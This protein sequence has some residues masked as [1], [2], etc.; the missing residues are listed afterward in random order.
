MTY[1]QTDGSVS[2]DAILTEN[3]LTFAEASTTKKRWG[4]S[5]KQ[6]GQAYVKSD[7]Y[8]FLIEAVGLQIN[9]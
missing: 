3:G 5:E 8:G 7:E 9:I 1:G 4:D 6:R 2:M